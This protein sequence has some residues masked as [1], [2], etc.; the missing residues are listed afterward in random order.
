MHYE[1]ASNHGLVLFDFDTILCLELMS[2][3]FKQVFYFF[4]FFLGSCFG[5]R[6]QYEKM[7]V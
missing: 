6:W 4:S 7:D 3:K 1:A 2:L 5:F